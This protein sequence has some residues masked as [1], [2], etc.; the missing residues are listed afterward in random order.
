MSDEARPYETTL[1]GAVWKHKWLVAGVIAATVAVGF[2][3]GRFRPQAPEFKAAAWVVVQDPARATSGLASPDAPERFVGNQVD[4]LGSRVVAIRAVELA[5]EMVPPVS[6]LTEELLE[7]LTVVG[8]PDSNLIVVTVSMDDAVTSVVGVNVLVQ[9]YED[10]H[11]EDNERALTAALARI[12]AE[13][14]ALEER[15]L[16]RRARMT[17]IRGQDQA[18]IDLGRQFNETVSQLIQL[19]EEAK[20]SSDEDLPGIRLR[21]GDLQLRIDLFRQILSMSGEELEVA[22]LREEENLAIDRRATLLQRRDQIVVDA[23]LLP[24]VAALFSPAEVATEFAGLGLD[25]IIAVSLVLG[26][27]AGSTLAL[28][29]ETRQRIF[30][31]RFQPEAVLEAPLLADVPDFEEEKITSSLPVRDAPRSAS[32]EAYRFAASSLELLAATQGAKLLVVVSG[33]PGNGKTTTIANSALAAARRGNRVLV[34]DADFGTEDLTRLFV[35]KSDESVVGLTDVVERG[36][37]LERAVQSV[38]RENQVTPGLLSR[39]RHPVVAADLLRSPKVR[40]LFE[41]A[42]EVYELVLVDT[43]SFLQVAY[44][45]TLAA[46]GDAALVIVDHRSSIAELE[47]VARRLRFIGTPVAGYVYNRSP[48]RDEMATSEGSLREILG[49]EPG[50]KDTGG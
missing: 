44:A 8:R 20:Q 19:Q 15:G 42:K 9:A 47:E 22:A 31:D 46:Y 40:E 33:N 24:S 10:L 26:G 36:W 32:A 14:E 28:L 3:Y 18:R 27:L 43:P 5:M 1:P 2:G 11:Q 34:V 30:I 4:I 35:G 45:S 29:A 25:R 7:D 49:D 39:G 50:V 12:D 41:Q 6:L 23:E 38:E 48:L 37:P 16:V 13:L 21:L 17:E